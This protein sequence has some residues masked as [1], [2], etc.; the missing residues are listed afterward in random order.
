MPGSGANLCAL[1]TGRAVSEK[2]CSFGFIP[3]L[4]VLWAI[5]KLCFWQH[6]YLMFIT[7]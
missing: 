7:F 1:I 3:V 6:L 5:W 2:G 4:F